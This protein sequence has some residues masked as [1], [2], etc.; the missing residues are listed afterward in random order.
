MLGMF[1]YAT[2][3]RDP[4]AKAN[5][6]DG[7]LLDQGYTLVWIG[8]EVDV[9]R[10]SPTCCAFT[11]RWPR[12]APPGLVRSEDVGGPQDARRWEI[13]IR[14]FGYPVVDPDDPQLAYGARQP[15]GPRQA[16]P[17]EPVAHLGRGTHVTPAGFDA[18][19]AIYEVVYKAEDP[20]LVGLGPPPFAT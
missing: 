18:A 14:S 15:D 12:T 9:P 11:R 17:R 13:G 19:A 4:R 6:G 2:G 1:D 7:F 16:V 8:W 5:F 10:V 20:T 3:S